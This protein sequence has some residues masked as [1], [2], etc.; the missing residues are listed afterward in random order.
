MMKP[1]RA[2]LGGAA[3]GLALLAPL[4]HADGDFM[5][6]TDERVRVSLGGMRVSSST[7]IRADSTTGVVGTVIN[8]EGQFGLDK[9]DY[10]PKFEV[11]VRAGTRNR[12]W[13]N[14]FTLDRDGSA[15]VQEPISFRDVVLQPGEPLQS[16]L[17]LRLLSLTYGYSFWHGEKL[18]LAATLG[19]TSVSINAQAKVQTQQ[20]HVNET[21][22]AAGPFPTP[23][24]AA[25]W[26]IA[27]HFY[28]DGRVQYLNLHINDLD[29]SLGMGEIDLLYRIHQNVSF[30]L[31]YTEIKAHVDSTKT[32]DSGLFDF[33]SKGPQ[34][35]VRV[36]F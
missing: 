19:I 36:S 28:L 23:G 12:L 34:L 18:E 4:A 13:L 9:S 1:G 35:F 16:E 25:T 3:L 8:G 30:A 10:E 15:V 29:G 17:D 27:K 6:P 26:A 20:V 5:S 11:M 7:T 14:Y 31:G 24:L 33:N 22:T 21:E 2:T 32:S